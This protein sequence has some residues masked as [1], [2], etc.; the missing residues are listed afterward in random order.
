MKEANYYRFLLSSLASAC[1]LTAT[2]PAV[3]DT[4]SNLT[5][6]SLP[7]IAVTAA[8]TI[9]AGNYTAANGQTFQNLPTFCRVAA[10]ATPTSVTGTVTV[11]P[12]IIANGQPGYSETGTWT[13]ET[14][15]GDYGGTDRYASASGNGNNTATWQTSKLPP[16]S[17][18]A[19]LSVT[20]NPNVGSLSIAVTSSIFESASRLGREPRTHEPILRRPRA[21]LLILSRLPISR[22][23]HGTSRRANSM[24][25][26][27]EVRF[28]LM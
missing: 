11:N 18:T 7:D 14:Q 13:T 20:T 9:P 12:I 17:Y 8:Q 25:P 5:S 15:T 24:S 23:R 28:P 2:E 4:C 16:G 1:I 21:R 27:P 10:T 26:P 22:A 6:L 19:T 3:A